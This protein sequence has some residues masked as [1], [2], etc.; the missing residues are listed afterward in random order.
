ME[1]SF[2]LEGELLVPS[3]AAV[4][5]WSDEMVNGHHIGGLVA[6]A[7]E[8]DHLEPGLQVTRLTVDMFRPV[9]MTPLRVVT[10]P[11][12][13]GRRLRLVEVSVFDGDVEV[14]RGS[15]LLLA[16]SEHPGGAPWTPE[17]W[18]VPAP[19]ELPPPDQVSRMSWEIRR[20]G[21][22]GEGQGKVWMRESVPFVAG[23]ALSPLMRA[24]L[25]ADF[26]NPLVNSAPGGLAFINADLTMYIA[27]DPVGEWIGMEA[28]GHLGADG[29][30]V[31]TAWLHDELGR[32]GHSSA[33]AV[34]D[35]RLRQGGPPD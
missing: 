7:V 35:A 24:A 34:P 20:I 29:I 18:G 27:R 19:D 26:A 6:W 4:S 9:P 16:R 12:R 31:G 10:R 15:A 17:A 13:M 2:T 33:S 30:A 22:W 3:M 25:S 8:R 14:T 21:A 11:G 23:E 5:V 32:F 28:A 1:P